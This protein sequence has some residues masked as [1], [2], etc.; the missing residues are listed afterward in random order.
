MPH[1]PGE[2]FAVFGVQFVL[3]Q[4]LQGPQ[5]HDP[6]ERRPV[7]RPDLADVVAR[8]V[9]P[10]LVERR[11]TLPASLGLGSLAS[12]SSRARRSSPRPAVVVVTV[13]LLGAGIGFATPS[14]V[15]LIMW[16]AP[17]ERGGIGGRVNE[18]IVEAVGALGV[19]VLGSV[20]VGWG[21][22]AGRYPGGRRGR[23]ARR[24]RRG[25]GHR[26]AASQH[27]DPGGRAHALT[28]SAPDASTALST[29][30]ELVRL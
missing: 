7:L 25:A 14:G 22:F 4:W 8:P 27:V 19:A 3:T 20:L 1:D 17:P 16:S 15:E 23:H 29:P 28:D 5:G 6:L 10:R 9:Q 2:F 11:V 26:P 30:R 13:S 12:G 18:T 24:R 21:S